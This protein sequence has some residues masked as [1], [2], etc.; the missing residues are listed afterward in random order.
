[1]NTEAALA[2]HQQRVEELSAASIRALSGEP[3]L[4]YRG[5]RLYRAGS[6]VVAWAPHLHPRL[7]VDDFGS[8]RGASDGTALRILHS[9][10]ALHLALCPTDRL[11]GLIFEM[12]EQFRVESLAGAGRTGVVANLR[13]RHVTWS[14]A[15]HA[16]GLTE[17]AQGLLIYTVA[18][19]GRARATAEPVVEETE[20]LLEA[21]RFGLAPLIGTELASLRRLRADQ[22]AYAVAA[23]AI[24]DKVAA[25]VAKVAEDN[26]PRGRPAS[27]TGFA[28]FPEDQ[29][30]D[31]PSSVVP[32]S[33]DSALLNGANGGYRVFTHAYDRELKITDLIRPAQ[34]K[35]YRARL[36][37]LVE[38]AA[39]NVH[40][41]GRQLRALLA[42]P[43]HD[44]W[45]SGQEEGLVDGRTLTRLITTPDDRRLFRSP[46]VGPVPD[47]L[48]TVLLDC[49]G[50]MRSQHEAVATLLDVLS[51]ALD[52][53]G[54]SNEI[55]GFT[56][57][58]WNG[59][60]AR[61][62]WQRAGRPAHPGRLNEQRHLV[63]KPA[64]DSWRRA[65]PGIAGLL[66]QDLY[67]EAL[68]GE[69]VAWAC[70]RMRERPESRRLLVV[71]SDGSP[72][73]SA[74][75]LANDP[76][77]LDQHLRDVVGRE[78]STGSVRILGL[79]VGLDLSPYYPRSQA[80]DLV[81]GVDHGTLREVLQLLAVE[82]IGS[83]R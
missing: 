21:S 58:A 43:E 37:D 77:Y 61:R 63:L 74:T 19:V 25:L 31:R 81:A 62:D 27:R 44:G 51:R 36:D 75:N 10:P 24:A 42:E 16:S 41:L 4:H 76:Q 17:T 22:A 38:G 30:D 8:F 15:F 80:I 18:Q 23:R 70:A 20:D 52:L 34:L 64:D 50:S 66:R 39:I 13:H 55:L 14:L 1:M 79:G 59:G 57:A 83:R 69:A 47:C 28:L 56:T 35:E 5:G 3:D 67:R 48:V 46:R 82:T 54:V 2:R 6:P 60:R 72:M 78:K 71:V 53:A 29:G 12:L 33:G 32:T 73:D 45:D 9:D 68:D 26:G 49:S 11:P 65:R 7:G 40:R